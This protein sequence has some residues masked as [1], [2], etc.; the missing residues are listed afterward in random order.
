MKFLFKLN[1]V[2]HKN[3]CPAVIVGHYVLILVFLN[4]WRGSL[5]FFSIKRMSRRNLRG[6]FVCHSLLRQVAWMLAVFDTGDDGV[7]VMKDASPICRP[8]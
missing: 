6:V 1:L 3:I 7:A 5:S 2:C 8:A 4:V